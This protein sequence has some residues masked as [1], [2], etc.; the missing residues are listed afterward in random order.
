MDDYLIL[1]EE[2]GTA[3]EIAYKGSFNVRISPELHKQAIIAAT[4]GHMSL[5]S[6]VERSI[7]QAV[8]ARN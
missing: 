1:C 8:E 7:Q 4:A 6:F 5:N 3:P 2:E